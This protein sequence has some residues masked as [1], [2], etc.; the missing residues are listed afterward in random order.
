MP[1]V[2][3]GF[4]G[5]QIRDELDFV[6]P[7]VQPEIGSGQQESLRKQN[8]LPLFTQNKYQNQ[9]SIFPSQNV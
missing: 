2:A 6:K 4:A 3:I 5:Y 9:I 8:N 7:L 1:I